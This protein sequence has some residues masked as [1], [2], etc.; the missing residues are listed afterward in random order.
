MHARFTLIILAFILC[1]GSP[2]TPSAQE[3]TENLRYQEINTTLARQGLCMACASNIAEAYVKYPDSEL[4]RT[5]DTALTGNQAAIQ[6][7]INLDAS[8]PLPAPADKASFWSKI[9]GGLTLLIVL[10]LYLS[11]IVILGLLVFSKRFRTWLRAWDTRIQARNINYK[12]WAAILGAICIAGVIFSDSRTPQ[13]KACA[14][15]WRQCQDNQQLIDAG[16]HHINMASACER[17]AGKKA[18]YGKPEF[19]TYSFSNYKPGRDYIETGV[20][21]LVERDALFQNSFGTQVHTEVTC[22]YDLNRD[23]VQDVVIWN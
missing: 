15:D 20:A 18:K 10:I 14:D 8:V 3:I 5:V 1:I 12:K 7:L 2:D 17:A 13:E 6:Q 22:G 9:V 21:F 4:A 16:S 11:V 23:A 19:P